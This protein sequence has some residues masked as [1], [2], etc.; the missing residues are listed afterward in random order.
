MLAV[1]DID[2]DLALLTSDDVPLYA[3]A[4]ALPL[5]SFHCKYSSTLFNALD[6]LMSIMCTRFLIVGMS[7]I[8]RL[9]NEGDLCGIWGDLFGIWGGTF[10]IWGDL[11]GI[12]GDTFGIWGDLFGILGDTFGI[13]GDLAD[14]ML[15]KHVAIVNKST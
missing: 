2:I 14:A 13:L 1:L 7:L 12:W 11:C 3:P 10:G 15:L 4:A 6:Y 9:V 5:L 8:T